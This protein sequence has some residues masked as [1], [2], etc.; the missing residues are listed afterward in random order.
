MLWNEVIEL[1]NL[2]QTIVSG[3]P[4]NSYTYRKI[5]ADKQSVRQ[6]EFY[7]AKQLGLKPQLMFV[8]RSI[9]FKNDERLKYKSKEYEIIR[10]F[11][12]GETIEVICGALNNG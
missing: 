1:G 4:I 8:I 12:K 2:T 6:N 11:D 3:E 10:T 9:E 7:E 5:F